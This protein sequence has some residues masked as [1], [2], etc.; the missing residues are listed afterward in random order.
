MSV[1]HPCSIVWRFAKDPVKMRQSRAAG[2]PL[3]TF[4]YTLQSKKSMPR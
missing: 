3:R 4:A 2:M 1:A